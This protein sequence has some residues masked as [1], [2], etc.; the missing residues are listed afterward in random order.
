MISGC[1]SQ[2]A[3]AVKNPRANAGDIRGAGST[4]RTGRPLEEGM[5]SSSS[6]LAWRTPP[7]RNLAGYSPWGHT[8]ED[9]SEAT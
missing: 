8:E 9:M 7:Q 1:T 5:A 2:V 3:L 6:L 4:P